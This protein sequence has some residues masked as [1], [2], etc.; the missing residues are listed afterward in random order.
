MRR[1]EVGDRSG[2][3]GC[4]ETYHDASAAVASSNRMLLSR[5]SARL[6]AHCDC[7]P[8]RKT[9]TQRADRHWLNS[10]GATTRSRSTGV[11]VTHANKFVDA[12]K[13]FQRAQWRT[14]R[15]MCKSRARP[16]ALNASQRS[17]DD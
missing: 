11:H 1:G 10:L 4:T 12:A 14:S 8:C 17:A 13:K 6:R 7:E 15:P 5:L 9:H 16:G 2:F 3:C